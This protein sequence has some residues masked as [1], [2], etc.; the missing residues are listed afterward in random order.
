MKTTSKILALAT[1]L[2]GASQGATTIS[3]TLGTAFK[4]SLGV[5]IISGA[6]VMLVADTS[7][8]GF[9]D[10]AGAVG[11]SLTGQTGKTITP[12]Q[13][14]ITVGSLFGGDTVVNTSLSGASASIAGILPAVDITAYINKKFAIVWW[15]ATPATLAGGTSG[16]NF[17][18]ISLSDWVFPSSDAGLTYSL[19]STD[20]SLSGSFF[21]TSASTTATQIGN[22]SVGGSFFTGSG[23]AADTGSTAIRSATFSVVPEPSAA[24]LGAIGVLGLLRRRRN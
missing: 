13:A 11:A 20:A 14:G 10:L 19:S 24:L 2:T 16:Q 12:A 5:N 1:L 21:S 22:G 8:N 18:M 17:G 9:L 4:D 6:L 23:T 15:N 3:G 7:G